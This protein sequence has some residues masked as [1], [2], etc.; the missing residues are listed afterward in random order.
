[1]KIFFQ[2]YLPWLALLAWWL[3]A[4]MTFAQMSKLLIYHCFFLNSW[5]FCASSISGFQQTI[6]IVL[7]IV[8]VAVLAGLSYW[9]YQEF[10]VRKNNASWRLV[11]GLI[12]VAAFLVLPFTSN[13]FQYYFSL[14]QVVSQGV[15][16][17]L[18]NFSIYRPFYY[19]ASNN[20]AYS[21]TSSGTMYGPIA[22]SLFTAFYQLS[23]G[24]LLVF[25]LLWKLLMVGVL[26]LVG[27]LLRFL[28]KEKFKGGWW[29]FW[30]LQP[31]ILWEWVANGHF[32]GLWI[33]FVLWAIILAKKGLWWAVII[34]LFVAVW[35]K[36]VPILLSPWFF[37]WWWQSLNKNNWLKQSGLALVG[38]LVG[39]AVSILTWVP[40]WQGWS[41]FQPI[42]L[43]SKW[44]VNSL[45]GFI[46]YGLEPWAKLFLGSSAHW[47][48]TV[49]THSLLLIIS[50]YLL[51]PYLKKV[52]QLLIKK[53]IWQPVDYYQAIFISLL[54]YIFIWQKSFWPW[55]IIWLLP[56]GWLVLQE[57][58]N[59][60]LLKAVKWLSWSPL[61]FYVITMASG[62]DIWN[63][64]FFLFIV[65][66]I[67]GYPLW[68]IYCWR[69]N[70][71]VA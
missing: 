70:N 6:Q 38:L 68:Q 42:I 9:L 4:K 22:V 12:L 32:D 34:A 17:Y 36:L 1:M 5:P 51:W 18:E 62:G 7:L 11:I 52:A 58:A 41:V 26:A 69:K 43:Q 44:V 13:D 60:Y 56:F 15:N 39:A 16:P 3:A 30:L 55:Y 54:V 50:L 48:L 20:S 49:L 28:S 63:I 66:V 53:I 67:M 37:L 21:L 71:Y 45:F 33:I 65:V 19:L 23:A 27:L 29:L 47:W 8:I 14:G 61:L 40:Y 64:W 57:S 59:P 24:S 25:T 35:I 10:F 2:K 46:Y 31:L